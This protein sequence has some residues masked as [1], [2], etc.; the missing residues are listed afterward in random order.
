MAED[1]Q[2]NNLLRWSIT[3]TNTAESPA[4]VQRNPE[5]LKILRDAL[6]NQPSEATLMSRQMAAIKATELSLEDRITAF[7]N[8]QMILEKLDNA[9]N[10]TPLKLWDPLFQ[11]LEN[12]EEEMRMMAAWCISTAVQNNERTQQEVRFDFDSI[13]N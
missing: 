11:E 12:E 5:D 7:D 8:L 3:N 1:K 13:K 10:L 4:P 9:N 2:L 6:Y